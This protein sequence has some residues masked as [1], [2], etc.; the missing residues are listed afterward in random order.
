MF[1]EKKLI[2]IYIVMLNVFLKKVF[3]FV[4]IKSEK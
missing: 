4:E 2:I 3:S 1:C